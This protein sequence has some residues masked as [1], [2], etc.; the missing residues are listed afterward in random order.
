MC[1][2]FEPLGAAYGNTRRSAPVIRKAAVKVP[3][4]LLSTLVSVMWYQVF[5]LNVAIVSARMM[6]EAQS[7]ELLEKL[8]ICFDISSTQNSV[9]VN[10][11]F[12]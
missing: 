9:V 1:A 10:R 7:I 2:S 6:V 8:P 11:G 3:F 4:A 12:E 5:P